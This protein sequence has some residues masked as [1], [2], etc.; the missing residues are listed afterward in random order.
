M[1]EKIYVNSLLHG[2]M[3]TLNRFVKINGRT[4]VITTFRD[5]GA[6][7]SG[8]YGNVRDNAIMILLVWESD[9]A[10][11]MHYSIN[12]RLVYFH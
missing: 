4:K 7:T 11:A 5:M 1:K 6:N 12:S 10:S 3:T 2:S 9:I 8:R